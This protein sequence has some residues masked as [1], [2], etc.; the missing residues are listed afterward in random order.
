VVHLKG[1][2]TGG[3]IVAGAIFELPCGYGPNSAGVHAV[4]SNNA[5]G[6]VT[7]FYSANCGGA[8]RAALVIADPPSDN[9]WV[10]LD[11]ITFRA[12]GS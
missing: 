4:L 11:G 12:A 3:S 7:I 5:V 2:V 10:S 8:D 1:V 6:R 9:A